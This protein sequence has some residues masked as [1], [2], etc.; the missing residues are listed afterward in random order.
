MT[1]STFHQLF[2]L[3]QRPKPRTKPTR[4]KKSARTRIGVHHW[5]K[6]N[7]VPNQTGCRRNGG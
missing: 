4:T 5:M 3:D 1:Y 7:P 6:M 2:T